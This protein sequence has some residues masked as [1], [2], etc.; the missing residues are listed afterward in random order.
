MFPEQWHVTPVALTEYKRSDV[1]ATDQG[2]WTCRFESPTDEAIRIHV[3]GEHENG[4]TLM[5]KRHE[6]RTASPN[7][8][9]DFNFPEGLEIY[10]AD[11]NLDGKT[12]ILVSANHGGS[13][14]AAGNCRLVFFLSKGD[15]YR[16]SAFDS[17]TLY[18]NSNTYILINGQPAV[19]C[20]NYWPGEN[21]PERGINKNYFI[22]YLVRIDG[23]NLNLDLHSFTGFPK[24][25]HRSAAVD[26]EEIAPLKPA[27]QQFLIER[28]KPVIYKY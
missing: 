9:L 4:M 20:T 11:F 1:T 19:L 25:A 27:Q 7:H 2:G 23:A 6:A 18:S 3:T 16:V 8:F 12:D 14:L 15:Q 17:L 5:L 26:S 24:I 13:G 22:H 28:M 21:L 10:S